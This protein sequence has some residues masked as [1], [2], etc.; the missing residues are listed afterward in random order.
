VQTVE[1]W[2]TRSDAWTPDDDEKLAELVLGHI[3][4][5]STQLK[6]FEEAANQLG[7]T[8]A[9]CGYRWNGVVRKH[10]SEQIESAKRERKAQS[11]TVSKAVTESLDSTGTTMTSADSMKEVLHFLEQYDA[12]YQRILKQMDALESERQGLQ[13]R[14]HD[15]E[16]ELNRVPKPS[17]APMTP[18]QLAEDSKALFAIMERARKLLEIDSSRP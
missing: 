13:S 16:T 12:Q 4:S 15:L 11:R 8:N 9:A 5:G 10:Y 6:A 17:A 3:K 14:V 18:E 1:R 2:V 7:R